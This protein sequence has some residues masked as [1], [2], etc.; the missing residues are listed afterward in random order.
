[1]DRASLITRAAARSVEASRGRGSAMP[2]RGG[3]RGVED[4]RQLLGS[5]CIVPLSA[6]SRLSGCAVPPL[7]RT[8]SKSKVKQ[9][10]RS[11]GQ[12]GRRVRPTCPS[13]PPSV[14][15]LYSYVQHS[16]RGP[17]RPWRLSD[18]LAILSSA[19]LLAPRRPRRPRPTHTPYVAF[20]ES[21]SP[22]H[23]HRHRHRG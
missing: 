19:C 9:A 17:L 8:L 10:A 11:S 12:A 21:R 18:K 20:C 22:R 14:C 15:A 7:R 5:A 2:L 23:R 13:R 3:G 4:R 16:A 6:L 1:M